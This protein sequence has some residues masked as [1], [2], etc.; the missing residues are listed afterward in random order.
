[1]NY[2]P[3]WGWGWGREVNNF[4]V[5]FHLKQAW[6][7]TLFITIYFEFV[8]YVYFIDIKNPLKVFTGKQFENFYNILD[9]LANW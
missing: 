7:I 1:M 2:E 8:K 4:Y 6:G 5:T 9:H 3:D